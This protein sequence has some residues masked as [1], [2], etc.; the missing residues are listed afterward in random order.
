MLK[1]KTIALVGNPNSGKTSL[2]NQLTGLRQK[3]GNFPGITVDRKI[4]EITLEKTGLVNL[5]D[6]PGT[7]SLYPTSMDE[8]VVLNTLLDSNNHDYPD[9]IVY[10]LDSNYLENH[11]L[12]LS[13]LC[14]L[15][16]NLILALNMTDV[17]EGNGKLID[18]KKLS[19]YLN[20]PVVEINGRKGGE[21]V[22]QLKSLMDELINKAAAVP[23][24][25]YELNAQEQS[26]VASLDTVFEKENDYQKL[27]VIQHNMRLPFLA[28][29]KKI[30]I[31]KVVNEISFKRIESQLDEIMR[32]FQSFSFKLKG[33]IKIQHTNSNNI[34]E[35]L[36]N[37]LTHP[38]VG[39]IVF[40]FLMLFTFQAIFSWA[41]IPMDWIDNSFTSLAE[42]V[43]TILPQGVLN[44]LITEGIIP[45]LS[46][47]AMFIPQIFILFFIIS[48]F[49]E[50]GYMSRAVYMF[51]GIMQRFGMNGRSIVALISG[52]A[53]AVPAIMST[54]IISNWK[55]RLITI[56]VTPLIS[57]SARIPVYAILIAFLIPSYKVLYV[58]N[59]QAL[60][61]MGLYLLGIASAL[62]SAYV[63]KKILK[64][65]EASFLMI[66]MPDYKMPDWKNVFFNVSNKIKSFVM[67]AGKVIFFISIALWILASYG[68]NFDDLKV[69]K[70]TL[71]AQER[72][73]SVEETSAFVNSKKL[74]SSY[75]GQMGKFI[76]PAIKPLGF[77]WKIGIALVTS[78]AAREVF[79]GTMSTL[80]S[81]GND[82]P[83]TIRQKL[84]KEVNPDTGKPVF[85]FAV[86]LSLLLFYVFAL[87]CMSTLAVVYKETQSIKW[88]I[89]QFVYMGAMAYFASLIAYQIFK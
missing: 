41:T 65:E 82:S 50:I 16:F 70:Y 15:K 83:Q 32:R 20:I 80:Y 68:G 84:A 18:T 74:E 54:R 60:V 46:G 63:L 11:F 6:L 7:Y 75:A 77:D 53:C 67:V 89:I 24:S 25:F 28:S 88:P 1:K 87:Q 12:L 26:L 43:S 35:K 71:E 72:G 9:L 39:P 33:F 36:D 14:D 57:C 58:F 38:I 29:E 59:S 34:S 66:E 37:W 4:S 76:E 10:V 19:E 64:S 49:E 48:M 73:Y 23:K 2:F 42:L 45:G 81:I 61:F 30:I 44:N 56:M 17:L 62:L 55:E 40:F 3:V 13:Q 69:E 8:N 22:L 79:V 52:G 21:G 85:T 5:I 47:I 27:L 31:E 78:F 86:A 51:D